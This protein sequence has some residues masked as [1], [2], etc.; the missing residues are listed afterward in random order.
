MFFINSH[1][2]VAK[3]SKHRPC[4]RSKSNSRRHGV[5]QELGR[6]FEK[7]PLASGLR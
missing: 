5:T 3:L 1:C 4:W 2:E 6:D 7:N